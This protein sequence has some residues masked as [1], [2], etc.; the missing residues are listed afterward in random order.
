VT[1]VEVVRQQQLVL[2]FTG[3][4]GS[5]AEESAELLFAEAVRLFV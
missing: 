3:G 2:E 5:D 4:A 1:G